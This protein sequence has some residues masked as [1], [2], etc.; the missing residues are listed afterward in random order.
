MQ[1]GEVS[2]VG[3]WRGSP[4]S[5]AALVQ[6]PYAEQRKCKRCRRLAVR[7]RDQCTMHLGRWS[8]LSPAAGRA[9]S[10]QLAKLERLGLLPLELLSLPVWRGLM[11]LPTSKR[12][13]LR[14]ALMQAWD[15][16]FAAPVRWAAVQRQAIDLAKQPGRRQATAAWYENQ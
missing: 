14:L 2:R 12:A 7:G 6:R 8:P 10:R 5:L 4:N 3:G 16:R 9:E 13:P 11:G 1:I 15:K